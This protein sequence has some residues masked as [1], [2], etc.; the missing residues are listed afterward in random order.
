MDSLEQ[1]KRGNEKQL[2]NKLKHELKLFTNQWFDS[3]DSRQQLIAILSYRLDIIVKNFH[4]KIFIAIKDEG[5]SQND[6][7]YRDDVTFIAGAIVRRLIDYD[8]RTGDLKYLNNKIGKWAKGVA[9]RIVQ[10]TAEK[11]RFEKALKKPNAI[12]YKKWVSRMD[13]VER[14]DHHSAHLIYQAQPIPIIEPFILGKFG[15]KMRYP[16][17]VTLGVGPEQFMNCRCRVQYVDQLGKNI[18]V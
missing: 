14:P 13:G 1:L 6:L 16:G 9:Q 3:P 5:V 8:S 4:N 10:R 2:Y 18:G 12:I 17:D 11:A 7:S 15:S